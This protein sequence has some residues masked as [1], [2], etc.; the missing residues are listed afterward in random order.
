MPPPLKGRLEK[1]AV[2]QHS[3]APR[4]TEPLFELRL[5][6]PAPGSRTASRSLY[7][8]LRAAIVDGRLPP[9]TRLPPTRRSDLLGVSRNT[10]AALYERLA[11]EGLVKSRRGSG[12]FVA[13]RAV[14]P[15]RRPPA[16]LWHPAARLN[17]I[18]LRPDIAAAIGFWREASGD[19]RGAPAQVDFRPA[20]V[21]SRLFPL[22]VFRRVSLKQM[23]LLEQRPAAL[24]SPQGHQGNHRL[25]VAITRHIAVTRAVVCG[26]ED[27]LVTSGAQQAFDLLARTLVTSGR[28]IVAVEEPGYPPMRAAFL[29]AGARVVPVRVDA[30]GVVVDAIPADAEVICVCPSHQFPL[31]TALSPR[32]RRQLVSLARRRGALII[33]DDYDGEFRF[34]GGALEALRTREAAEL[35][36]YVGTFS[37]CMLPALRLGFIAAPSWAMPTLVAAKNCTDWHSPVPVQ[38]SVAA[39][40]AEGHLARHVRRMREIYRRRRATLIEALMRQLGRW[41]EPVPSFYGLH[42]TAIAKPGVDAEAAAAAALA[43]G[44]RVHTLARYFLGEPDRT[45]MIFGYGVADLP[46]IAHGLGQLRETLLGQRPRAR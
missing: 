8:Q 10:A 36:F 27:V 25:R 26:P 29:A 31:G 13:S 32:R 6:V 30:E 24:R 17:P 12:V 9:G 37:K 46:H 45:G 11:A 21:D 38:A 40:I 42:V 20:L 28:T 43:A 2:G 44:V 33:E 3:A 22:E 14:P 1:K 5:E 19:E 16:P 15:P 23:R 4:V 7:E 39:F 35:V 41:L 18:W 34:E